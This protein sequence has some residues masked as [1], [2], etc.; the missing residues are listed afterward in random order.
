MAST[1][2][3]GAIAWREDFTPYGEKRLDPNANKD[4]EGFTGHVDDAATGLTYMQ[5]RYYDPVIGRFLS[6]DPVGFAKG[7]TGYF[8]RY[9]YTMNNPI[10]GIDPDGMKCVPTNGGYECAVDDNS[11]E[12]TEKPIF[13]KQEIERINKAYT[14]AVNRL[15]KDPNK[16]HTIKLGGKSFKAKA[17]DIAK[18]LINSTVS[19]SNSSGR[20]S[21]GGGPLS[22][23]LKASDGSFNLTIKRAAINRDRSGGTQFIDRDLA[24]TFIHEGIHT[25]PGESVFKPMFD[26]GLFNHNKVYNDASTLFY[27]NYNR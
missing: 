19:T 1:T 12:N 6:N 11:D 3:A 25:L 8:N 27:H 18:G 4:D 20:A 9:A 14:D 15:V 7:G 2:A 24:K 10:N 21:L 26:Q 16:H 22:P 23:S 17:G 5:A 13:T